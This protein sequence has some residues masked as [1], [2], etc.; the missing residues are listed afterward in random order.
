V[1]AGAPGEVLE[2]MC[3]TGRLSIPL[4]RD[5]VQLCCVDYSAEMLDVFRRKLEQHH[6]AAEVHQQDVRALALGRSF[7]LILLPFHSLSE[8]VESRDRVHAL[9]RVREHLETGGRF[10][11]TLHNPAVQVPQLDGVRRLLYDGPMPGGDRVLRVWSTARYHGDSRLGEA[12]QEYEVFGREQVLDRRELILRFAV[13]DRWTFEAEAT[14]AGLKALRLWGDY[15][16]GQF[17][18]EKSPFMVWEFGAQ[19]R[20]GVRPTGFGPQR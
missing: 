7:A 5:G 12:L 6:L 1:T 9:A 13:I 10:F 11:C 16:G 8:I 4:L 20:D 14:A 2:L 3:G 17:E 15:A 19:R 18:P